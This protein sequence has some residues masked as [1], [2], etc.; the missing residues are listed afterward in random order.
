MIRIISCGGK[1]VGAL[2]RQGIVQANDDGPKAIHILLSGLSQR[3][4]EF[5]ACALDWVEAAAA[6]RKAELSTSLPP[7]FG[8]RLEAPK[9]RFRIH[10]DSI[11]SDYALAMRILYHTR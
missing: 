3:D 7:N 11:A 6:G 10:R 8:K 1:V 5:G 2:L 9:H 4:F